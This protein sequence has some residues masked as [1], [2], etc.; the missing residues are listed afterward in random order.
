VAVS[1]SVTPEGTNHSGLSKT[2]IVNRAVSLYDFVDGDA[3]LVSHFVNAPSPTAA[4]GT[5]TVVSFCR[6]WLEPQC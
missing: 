5:I 1:R 2:D 6:R 3:T 4:G